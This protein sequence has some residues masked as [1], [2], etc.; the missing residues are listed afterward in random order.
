MDKRLLMVII[1]LVFGY[2]GFTNNSHGAD[3]YNSMVPGFFDNAIDKS[4]LFLVLLITLGGCYLF[5]S[6]ELAIIYSNKESE[7]SEDN[8]SEDNNS[9]ETN[10][11]ENSSSDCIDGTTTETP[12]EQQ[13]V[14]NDEIASEDVL[15]EKYG[16]DGN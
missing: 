3:T 1:I 7:N 8:N 16:V 5:K 12:S 15:K 13:D 10:S 14:T 4:K 6:K 2:I 11:E 9:E